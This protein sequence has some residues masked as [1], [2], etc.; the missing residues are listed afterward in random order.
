MSA[1]LIKVITIIG[2]KAPDRDS[3]DLDR[4]LHNVLHHILVLARAVTVDKKDAVRLH[5]AFDD[6]AWLALILL[7]NLAELLRCQL[8]LL[9]QT[10]DYR[11][12]LTSLQLLETGCHGVLK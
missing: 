8:E 6:D 2:D 4:A 11:P 3:I 7:D 10:A 12:L 1:Q 5:V 9:A